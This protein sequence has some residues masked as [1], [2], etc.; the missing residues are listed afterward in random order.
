MKIINHISIG[1]CVC[2][3]PFLFYSIY[4]Y[5]ILQRAVATLTYNCVYW[6]SWMQM[7][8]T[9]L[10]LSLYPVKQN[11]SPQILDHYCEGKLLNKIPNIEV[12]FPNKFSEDDHSN[13]NSLIV[14]SAGEHGIHR[15]C[16]S[17]ISNKDINLESRHKVDECFLST[18]LVYDGCGYDMPLSGN[19]FS[20]YVNHNIIDN[21]FV[22]YY[23]I[24]HLNI[25]DIPTVFEYTIM[26]IDQDVNV[27]HLTEKDMLTFPSRS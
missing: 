22:R 2:S 6:A 12:V 25:K 16:V 27:I 3:F 20:Y 26:C 10:Y 13:E 24:V 17:L 23:M 14:V 7:H 15:P 18:Q 8:C 1:L 19:G 5:G 4:K 21:V 11:H 9:K